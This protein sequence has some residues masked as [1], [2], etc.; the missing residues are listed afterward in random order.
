MISSAG[1][2][3]SVCLQSSSNIER[4]VVC[5]QRRN[6]RELNSREQKIAILKELLDES[7]LSDD[8]LLGLIHHAVRGVVGAG[9]KVIAFL[10]FYPFSPFSTHYFI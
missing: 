4:A 7:E 10:I 5:V 8:F 6:M 3:T 2:V 9:K 1:S